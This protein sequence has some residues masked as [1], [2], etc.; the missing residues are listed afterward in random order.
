ML[1]LQIANGRWCYSPPEGVRLRPP[2]GPYETFLRGPL[3]TADTE[4]DTLCT[5]VYCSLAP[6]P[7]LNGF[8][9]RFE[10]GST[11]WLGANGP[12]RI[13]VLDPPGP[14]DGPLWVAR[15]DAAMREVEV[16][17][18]PILVDSIDG[19]ATLSQVVQYPLDQLLFIHRLAAAQTVLLH[20]AAVEF[21]GGA[22]LFAGCSGAGKSTVARMLSHRKGCK[23]L[24]DD[25]VAVHLGATHVT[26]YGT[27]WPGEAGMGLNHALPAKALCFLEQSDSTRLRRLTPAE[28]LPA[29]LEV[30]SIAWYEPEVRDVGLETLDGLLASLPCY[31][32]SFTRDSGRLTRV[33]E[34]LERC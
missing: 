15:G 24:A 29:L 33:L 31:R 4:P 23:P 10:T 2:G 16:F 34:D 12:S 6:P 18:H 17:C 5:Q 27:P 20:S 21:G 26:A 11:W 7:A 22:V 25:R 8:R 32:L 30:A 3:P 1:E 14:A 13:L 9:R 28:A 19:Q